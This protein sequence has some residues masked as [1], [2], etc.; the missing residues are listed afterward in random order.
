MAI[1][2]SARR[3]YEDSIVV[4]CLNGSALT[5]NVLAR[6][7][8]SRVTALNLTA[9]QIGQDFDGAL[10]DL[11]DVRETVARH[12]DLLT[13]A[14]EPDDVRRA[15]ADGRIALILGM[16]DAEPIGRDLTRLR[17]LADLGVRIIQLT[18][19]RQSFVGTG[20]AE[21][22]SGLTRF[23]Q[24]VVAEMNR[25]GLIVDLAHCGPE[26][27]RGAI[28]AS[29]VPV[30]CS[31]ANP[32]AIANS[33]RNKDDDLIRALAARDGLIGM[34]TW[35]PIVYRGND[36]RPTIEDVLDCFDYATK[37]VGTASVVVGSD[38]CEDASPTPEAWAAIYGAGGQYPQVTAGLG[39]WYGF[40]TVNAAGFETIT[41]LPAVAA[42][43]LG[44]GHAPAAVKAMLGEN[45]LT[46][47]GRVRASAC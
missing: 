45:F 34:A 37:L 47:F 29:A 46:L 10:R 28:E 6:L 39:D 41:D 8:A 32:K 5:A 35:A 20:C 16:Q 17:T 24:K 21:P 18:H 19:N 42:G 1:A 13:I 27:T 14:C 25:L 11:A 4:D 7:R 22:D 43:L 3:L 2:E 33:P 30:M 9:V 12:A 15:K 23:G 31:H 38:L 44:R 26:T 40:E 36:R